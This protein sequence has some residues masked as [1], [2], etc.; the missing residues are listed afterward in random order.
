MGLTATDSGGGGYTIAP[1]GQHRARCFAVIDLGTQKV[2]W[3]GQTKMQHK[4]RLRWELSDEIMDGDDAK[5]FS[6]SKTYTLSLH[7]KA[8]L[9]HDLEAWRGKAFPAEELKGFELKKL[10]GAPCQLTVVHEPGKNNGSTYANVKAISPLAKGM[11]APPEAQNALVYYE[12]EDGKNATFEA[13]PDKLKE[14][15]GGCME[16]AK[17]QQPAESPTAVNKPGA[18]DDEIPF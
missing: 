14:Y 17:P 5:P 9:R 15:I 2:E 3:Q 6:I 4:V 13:F 16:W 8:A 1:A 10:L 11:T 18:D 7:E 12:V